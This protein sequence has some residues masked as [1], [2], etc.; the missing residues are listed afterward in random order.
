MKRTM[1]LMLSL[2]SLFTA[3]LCAEASALKYSDR[4]PWMANIGIGIGTGT[5]DDVDDT[6][7]E[8]RTGAVPQIRFGRMLG[9]HF[10]VS[11]NYQG[12]IIE[13][14]QYGDAEIDDAKIRRSL[15]DLAL[16]LTW[17]PGS[18]ESAW[19]GLYLRAGAGLGWS[20]TAVIPVEEGGKQEHGERI[21]DWGTG[22]LGEIGYDF[23]IS[24][25]STIGLTACYN[26]LDL[27]GEI[28]RTA[29]FSATSLTLSLYF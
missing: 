10:M 5:F 27:D 18:P 8:F 1:I 11:L 2:A 15:Q 25:N 20:G 17:F 12:W 3:V 22:Y 16:G 6:Q 29:W 24:D 9:R 7:R 28:V 23:W 4:R 26:Y 21:D 13:F 14:D 19:G